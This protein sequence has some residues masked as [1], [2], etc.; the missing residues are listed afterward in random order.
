MGADTAL[1]SLANAL[2]LLLAARSIEPSGLT[3]LA[4]FQLVMV[5]GVGL[6]RAT[7]LNPGLASQR[8]DGVAKRIPVEWALFVSLPFGI[9][10]GPF[11]P[12]MFG[13]GLWSVLTAALAVVGLMIFMS[14]DV[15]RYE[16]ISVGKPSASLL[17]DTVWL[18]AFGA[19][20][21]LAPP[22]GWV[23]SAA[24][25]IA[26][27]ACSNA[28]MLALRV[29]RV[30]GKFPSASLK[31]TLRL[32]RW[33]GADNLLSSVANFAPMTVTAVALASPSAGVYRLMQTALGPLN[34]VNSTITAVVGRNAWQLTEVGNVRS[35]R[36]QALKVSG[37]LALTT[38]TYLAAAFPLVVILTGL[39]S[40]ELPR[41]IAIYSF[42]A[43]CGAIAAPLSASALALGYQAIGLVIRI[44]VVAFSI[45]VSVA[46]ASNVW[47]PWQ[48][49]I[50]TVAIVSSSAGLVGWSLGYFLAHRREMGRLAE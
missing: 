42:S 49:P 37:L 23:L 35:L 50:G 47:L 40:P 3:P 44:F 16:N 14:Q 43:L 24:Y 26:A 38:L 20:Y 32:G 27:A 33:S 1:V 36:A 30:R 46:A 10:I 45:C 25:W 7:V 18:I 9:L 13:S 28:I 21:L 4:M 17:A 11:T 15:L 48:D 31:Q 2:V 39:E 29:R 5:T 34:I 19:A 22:S 41:V 12:L 8:A 6:Q